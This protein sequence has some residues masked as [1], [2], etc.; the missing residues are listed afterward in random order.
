MNKMSAY[1]RSVS[2]YY[3]KAKLEEQILDALKTT[4][5]NI[6]ELLVDD[7][8]ALDEFHIR[9]RKA[10]EELAQW[11]RIR[12][13]YSLLD[14]G[15]G[16]GGTGRYLATVFGCNVS[17]LDLTEEYCR[18]AAML[19]ARVGLKSKTFFRQGS[20]LAMPFADRN[21][22]IV[23]TEHVQM[24]IADKTGFYN[25]ISRVLRPGGQ[26][27]F[28]DIF[29]GNNEE[30]H[31]PVPWAADNAVSHLIAV[32]DLR[33]ILS[34]LGYIHVQWEDKSSE[35]AVFFRTVLQRLRG[36]EWP[37]VGLHLLMGDDAKTKCENMLGNLQNN[38]VRVVQ[39]V[40]I[41]G[42]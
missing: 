7:L 19:S 25:E 32:E 3:S 22:D 18:I 37:P 36:Q 6:D 12:A 34:A 35:S 31:Y 23:W 40:M 10:T 39:A 20:A 38:R 9:G 15:C 11:A 33:S 2:E 14:V 4:G 29:A 28:H 27:V 24:N 17:G 30:L 42:R 5:K 41:R 16:L 13:D 21:F 1:D 8:A 26:F